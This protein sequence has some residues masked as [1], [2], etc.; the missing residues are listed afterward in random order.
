[1]CGR[2][3]I[4]SC[5]TA[6]TIVQIK[7]NGMAWCSVLFPSCTFVL[8]RQISRKTFSLLSCQLAR[9]SIMSQPTHVCG[10]RWQVVCSPRRGS[11]C[12]WD[13]ETAFD[14]WV[15]LTVCTGTVSP[16]GAQQDGEWEGEGRGRKEANVVV[17]GANL[18]SK[19]VSYVWGGDSFY[20][21]T[22]CWEGGQLRQ[23]VPP[24]YPFFPE[25]TVVFDVSQMFLVFF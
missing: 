25:L 4:M 16:A 9:F 22:V 17:V 19:W 12:Q 14:N 24:S 15:L 5:V 21:S 20:L 7:M 8:T 10:L 11:V 13:L 18:L 23:P 3:F 2:L 6:A 1:M